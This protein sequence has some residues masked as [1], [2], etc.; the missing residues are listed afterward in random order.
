[1]TGI[2]PP[3]LAELLAATESAIAARVGAGTPAARALAR[4]RAATARALPGRPQAEARTLPVCRHLDRALA[5]AGDGPPDVARIATALAAVAPALRWW[6]RQSEDAVFA[7]GHANADVLGP[8][9]DSLEPRSDVWIGISLMAPGITYPDH[10]HPPEEVYI[11]LSEGDW[12]QESGPWHAPG[13]GG[14]IY[15]PPDTVH[16]MRAGTE[17]LLA[18]WCLPG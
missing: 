8:G 6:R 18:V 3:A 2:R 5:R 17:P 16:A 12:R 4:V 14:I 1:M 15:N 9:P 11:V 7:E 10:R 13:V